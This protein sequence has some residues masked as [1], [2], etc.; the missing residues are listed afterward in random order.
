MSMDRQ[1][2]YAAFHRNSSVMPS[3]IL[4]TTVPVPGILAEPFETYRRILE[5]TTATQLYPYLS[6]RLL[7]F[8]QIA[9]SASCLSSMVQKIRTATTSG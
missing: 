5:E 4:H 2:E 7:L 8:N 3:G 1:G 6:T 9:P